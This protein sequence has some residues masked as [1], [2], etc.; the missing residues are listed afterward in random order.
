MHWGFGIN[1][2]KTRFFYE[3]NHTFIPDTATLYSS[4]Q[5]TSTVRKTRPFLADA[6]GVGSNAINLI[7]VNK[8]K[9]LFQPTTM[10]IYPLP[11]NINFS[12]V[13]PNKTIFFQTANDWCLKYKRIKNYE[14]PIC[15]KPHG[16]NL[17]MSSFSC[18]W[19]VHEILLGIWM[20]PGEIYISTRIWQGSNVHEN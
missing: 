17:A 7:F 3:H 15:K 8:N 14:N 4:P 1:V 20:I 11:Y 9:N 19:F 10:C 16:V 2:E 6:L 12:T 5:L 13:R 18:R